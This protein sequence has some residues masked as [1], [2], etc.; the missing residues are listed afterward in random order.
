MNNSKQQNWYSIEDSKHNSLL[1]DNSKL[2]KGYSSK[3]A[4]EKLTGK[5]VK[6]VMKYDDPYDYCVLLSNENN[7]IYRDRRKRC[8]YKV[9]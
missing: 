5:K 9:I 1:E 8:Y 3:D 6:R 2:V 7:E 4:L